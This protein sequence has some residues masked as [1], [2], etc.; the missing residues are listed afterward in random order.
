MGVRAFFHGPQAA[1]AD[2]QIAIIEDYIAMGVDG[3]AIAANDPATIEPVIVRVADN[4]CG[5]WGYAPAD[6]ETD[7]VVDLH[8]LARFVE[9]W[10]ACSDP[11]IAA[12]TNFAD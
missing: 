9:G 4:E 10:I 3:I 12:C 7:C 8:D 5:A 2:A 6:L 1:E 11:D